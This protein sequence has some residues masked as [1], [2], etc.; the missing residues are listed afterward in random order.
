MN[1]LM[2]AL[3]Y[4]AD[5]VQP[6]QRDQSEAEHVER[7]IV[8]VFVFLR[9]LLVIQLSMSLWFQLHRDDVPRAVLPITSGA[10]AF[11]LAFMITALRRGDMLSRR[12]GYTDLVTGIMMLVTTSWLIPRHLHVGT[13]I[14]WAPG[15]M[16][17]VAA[18]IP[19]WL[20]SGRKTLGYGLLIGLIYVATTLPGTDAP[21]AVLINSLN[22]PM[23]AFAAAMFGRYAR[24]LAL[25]S[26]TARRQAQEAQSFLIHNVSGVLEA[27][28]RDGSE[29]AAREAARLRHE[30]H[31]LRVPQSADGP[32]RLEEVV[33]AALDRYSGPPVETI[34]HLGRSAQLTRTHAAA[35]RHALEA[36]LSNV[37]VHAQASKV[38]IHADQRGQ[39]WELSVT[40]DGIGFTPDPQRFG[41]GLGDQVVSSL[42]RHGINVT[43]TSRPQE[44]TWVALEGS[45]A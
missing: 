4:A 40:D 23:F 36:L 5:S 12:W 21:D 2:T 17:Q 9:F 41:F 22:Y 3:R 44:G 8:V 26:D 15:Y 33:Y 18:M 43:I 38:T 31:R 34:L 32:V 24:G 35:V 28:A 6:R 1:R 37:Q 19:A 7:G 39:G 27:L 13:W 29:N 16:D 14:H 45:Q 30:L 42:S 20:C 25:Q 10:I 11:S